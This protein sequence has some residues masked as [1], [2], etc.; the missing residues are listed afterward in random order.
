M[1]QIIFTIHNGTVTIKPL[2][3]KGPACEAATKVFED[4]LGGEITK[5]ART[6]EF[7]EEVE[8]PKVKIGGPHG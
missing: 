8:E 4:V 3:F 5:K 6:S 7:Y 1:E 2:G